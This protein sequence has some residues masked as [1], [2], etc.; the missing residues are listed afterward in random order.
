MLRHM[1]CNIDCNHS[2]ETAATK[3]YQEYVPVPL[4]PCLQI[5]QSVFAIVPAS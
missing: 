2:S 5:T 3:T 4:V 1:V